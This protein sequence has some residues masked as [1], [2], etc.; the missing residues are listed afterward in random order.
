M[1]YTYHVTQVFLVMRALTNTLHEW[2]KGQTYTLLF[3]DFDAIRE[4]DLLIFHAVFAFLALI[5]R[6][7]RISHVVWYIVVRCE[8]AACS[9]WLYYVRAIRTIS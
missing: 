9:A 8:Y 4:N 5:T 1:Q 7:S 2:K 6:E 3:M